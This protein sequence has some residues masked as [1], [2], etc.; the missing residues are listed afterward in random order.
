M[1]ERPRTSCGSRARRR[2][3]ARRWPGP[4]RGPTP[5]SSASRAAS[6]PTSRPCPSTSPTWTRGTRSA[7]TSPS[8]WRRSGASARCSSTT[9]CTTGAAAYMGEGDHATPSQRVHR[10]RGG[11]D[12]ARRPVPP[13]GR[14]G[15]RRRRRRRPGADV[16]GVGADRVPGLRDLRRVEGGDRAVGAVRARRARGP[17]QGAV[18]GRHPS[19][20]RR[21]ARRRDARPSCRPTRTPACPASPRRCVRGT[22]SP[23]DESADLHLG[24]DP[25]RRQGASRCCSSASRSASPRSKSRPAGEPAGTVSS[26][27][28]GRSPLSPAGRS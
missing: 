14:A 8:G 9:R 7:S 22:C 11:G 17:R 5:R 3:S 16:V 20:V 27:R 2:A 28:T 15:G 1:G 12:R 25:R 13:C 10:Q 4:A 19:G 21:H 6:T 23:A 26:G 18:G 24:R